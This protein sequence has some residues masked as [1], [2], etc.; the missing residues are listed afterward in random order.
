MGI[1]TTDLVTHIDPATMTLYD[2]YGN[3]Y[4]YLTDREQ[5]IADG[6]LEEYEDPEPPVPPGS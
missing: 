6:L 1:R 4:S 5:M 2:Q 3:A